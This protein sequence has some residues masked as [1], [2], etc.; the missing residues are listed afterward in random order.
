MLKTHM[1]FISS[2]L[3]ERNKHCRGHC[4]M[5]GQI[6]YAGRDV[7]LSPCAPRARGPGSSDVLS[8]LGKQLV[9]ERVS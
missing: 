1:I 9:A 3:F 2:C 6:N 5:Q 8:M 7:F 4:Y